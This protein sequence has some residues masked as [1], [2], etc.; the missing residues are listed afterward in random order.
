M[1][2]FSWV[3][4]NFQQGPKEFNAHYLPYSAGVLWAYLQTSPLLRNKFILGEFVW[5][6][7][8]VETSLQKIVDSDVVGFSTYVWN[9]SYN[10]ALAKRLK[11]ENPDCVIIFGGPEPPITDKNFFKRFPFIDFCVK[12][13]GEI[14]LKK[15]LENLDDFE[16][17]KTVK[18]LLIN[19]Q[20]ACI[21]TGSPERVSNLSEV[22]S[23]YL[24]GIFDK[25]MKDHPEIEWN[26]TIETDRGCPYQCTF[27]DWGSL[28]YNKIK[29]F[30]LER[31]YEELE[32]VGKN[33]CG[34]LSVTNANFGIFPERDSQIADKII[35]I[36]QKYGYP[37]SISMAWAKN[38]KE[39]VIDIVKKFI[40]SPAFNQGL[41]VSVQSMDVDVLENIKR[42]N[43][44]INKINEVFEICDKNNIPVYTELILGLPGETLDTWKQNFWKLFE[45]G[46]HTG[47]NV[48][49][50]QLLENAEMNLVQKKLYKI[51]SQ[52]VYDYMSGSYNEDELKE[53]IEVVVSTKDLPFEKMVD[54]HIFTWFLNTFHIQGITT[55][56][57]RVLVKYLGISYQEFYEKLYEHINNNQWLSDEMNEVKKYYQNWM[58]SGSINHPPIGGV[59]IHGWN[60]MHRTLMYIHIDSKYDE[61][62]NFIEDFLSKN[63]DL[64]HNFLRNLMD[65]QKLYFLDFKEI[66][67]FPKSAQ[68]D[69]D[70]LGFLQDDQEIK[71]KS[72][73]KF[74]FLE[75][76]SMNL[77]R[78]CENIYFGRKR[79]FGKTWI[80]K[81][82]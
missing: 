48:Y 11:E 43:L 14:T 81:V 8:S 45:L 21:D 77:I 67:N 24:L 31:V 75:D 49:Q 34:F 32:W 3:Q 61:V 51:K 71:N 39:E 78:F 59:E 68:F 44:E 16:S 62:F 33:K 27:C 26:A 7:D 22:P 25:L 57:S 23:P 28:T 73:Y 6:R 65:F 5:R 4:P 55:Y 29:K 18:G 63:Y 50:A 54:A 2:I 10:Y 37:Y 35:E 56:I 20:G 53:G 70:F 60:I 41:T 79:N 82:K 76:S 80:S 9:K 46:N 17:L 19:D 52:I 15:L 69:F 36:Q 74:E 38:Q 64:D 42:K 30:E 58:Y 1:K 47:I 72:N 40:K 13:E 12:Q 66:K